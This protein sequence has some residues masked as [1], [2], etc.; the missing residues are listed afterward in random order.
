MLPST[1]C[2]SCQLPLHF[3]CADLS[4]EEAEF[5]QRGKSTKIHILRKKCDFGFLQMRELKN[6][7]L[8]MQ[9]LFEARLIAIKSALKSPAVD[10]SSKE[11]I[12]QESVEQTLRVSNVILRNV[13]EDP[14]CFNVTIA[15]DKLDL[16]DP[17]EIV[18]PDNVVRLGKIG[19][20]NNRPRLL[21]LKFR[22]P[23]VARLVLRK[24]SVLSKTK[25]SRIMIR[26]DKT[27]MHLNHL[28]QPEV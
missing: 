6:N 15:N 28:K 20:N 27:P 25:Y 26:D 14:E 23:E 8:H 16:I 21:K 13:P 11:E 17:K 5:L 7:L 10:I 24:K 19:R 4:G 3:Q 9:S 2:H 18:S 1:K 22:S 12:I